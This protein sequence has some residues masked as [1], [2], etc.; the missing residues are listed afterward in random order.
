MTRWEDLD[1]PPGYPFSEPA[2]A[3]IHILRADSR[4]F[5]LTAEAVCK[6]TEVNRS[7]GAP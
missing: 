3:R 5:G 1:K 4:F 2:A 6:V 7:G